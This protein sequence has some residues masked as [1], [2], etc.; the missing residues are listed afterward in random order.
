MSGTTPSIPW[1]PA[2]KSSAPSQAVG[3]AVTKFK[4]GDLVG[5]GCIV[6]SCRTCPSCKAGEEQYCEVGTTLTYGQKDKYLAA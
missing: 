3:S 6:D 2:T 1:S 5:V 4:A